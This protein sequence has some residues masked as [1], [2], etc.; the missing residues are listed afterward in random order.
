MIA[1]LDYDG[2]YNENPAAWLAVVSAL[3]QFGIEVVTVTAR[4]KT[5]ENE[6]QMRA[7]GVCWPI[8]FAYDK[9]KKLAAIESG[10]RPDIWI[11]DNPQGIGDGTENTATQTVFE[12]ELRH[13]Y[14]VLT[15]GNLL[16]HEFAE[17]IERIETVL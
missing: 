11:D 9:P 12:I 2:T 3:G 14:K 1:S 4:R 7:A 17:L 15:G 5:V 8:V 13:A 6:Q 16:R 10:Y